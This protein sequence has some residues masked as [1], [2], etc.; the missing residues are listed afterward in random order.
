MGWRAVLRVPG[1]RQRR[2]AVSE[3]VR[4]QAW[5]SLASWYLGVARDRLSAP[6]PG[7]LASESPGLGGADRGG[8]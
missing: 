4:T 2:Q 5:D 7:V 3:A 1:R 8:P 6:K